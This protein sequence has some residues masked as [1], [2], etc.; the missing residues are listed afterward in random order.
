MTIL[1]KDPVRE[2]FSEC[3][4]GNDKGKYYDYKGEARRAFDAALMAYGYHFDHNSWADFYGDSD[5]RR[6]EI[7]DGLGDEVGLAVLS[8]HRMESGRWEFVGYIA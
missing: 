3:S 2:A 8:Y 4:T 5:S 1:R 7:C 6:I